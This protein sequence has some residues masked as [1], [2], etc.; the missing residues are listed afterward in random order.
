M[1]SRIEQGIQK[2]IVEMLD[3]VLA[4]GWLYYHCPNGEERSKVTAAILI[5]LGVKRG[6]ADLMFISPA[7]LTHAMEVKRP[8]GTL[9]KEQE[10][11]RDYCRAVGAPWA[12]VESLDQ[13]LRVLEEWGAL[14]RRARVMG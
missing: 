14:R 7:A 3:V 10:Q 13:A 2:S 1:V 8:N 12:V 4:R 9:T 5:G 6:I 11:F